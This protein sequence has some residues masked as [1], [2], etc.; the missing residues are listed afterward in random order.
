VSSTSTQDDATGVVQGRQLAPDVG[1]DLRFAALA[2]AVREAD[3][4]VAAQ[5]RIGGHAPEV[6]VA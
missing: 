2:I 1:E 5:G 4:L 3:L 6:L